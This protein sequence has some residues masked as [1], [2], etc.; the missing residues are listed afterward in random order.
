MPR[1]RDVGGEVLGE[2][3]VALEGGQEGEFQVLVCVCMCIWDDNDGV[4][5]VLEEIK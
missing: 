1:G 4:Q 2:V 3:G 5:G